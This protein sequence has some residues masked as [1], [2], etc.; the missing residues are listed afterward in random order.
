MS[1]F[2]FAVSLSEILLQNGVTLTDMECRD[3][4]GDGAIFQIDAWFDN[5]SIPAYFT[6]GSL[7]DSGC[8]ITINYRIKE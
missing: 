2:C 4:P 7:H 1:V 6:T 3:N 5:N 8:R